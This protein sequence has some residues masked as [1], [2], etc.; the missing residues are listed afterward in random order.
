MNR[1]KSVSIIL[2]A[3]NET[4]SM[5]ETVRVIL[6]TC[7]INDICELFIVLCDRSTTECI[8]AATT[9]ENMAG[10]IPTTIYYQN[11]PF[12][13][14]AMRE[15]FSQVK[16]SHVIMMSTDLE[17]D[18]YL[19]SKMIES[20]KLNPDSITTASR[21]IKGGGFKGY[22]KLKLVSNYF[23]QKG[24]SFLFFTRNTD[25]TYGYRIFPTKLM[26]SI[27]WEEEK[28]PFFLETAL[29]PLRLGVKIIELPTKWEARTEGESQN[30][31]FENF[32]YIKTVLRVRFMKKRS[33]LM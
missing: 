4:Y 19:V 16:G 12:V 11:K 25:L 7:D 21:W 22:S 8:S 28:H 17:T 6:D 32:K 2:P 10:N 29:K 23:F 33:I 9:V 1:F 27:R 30:A 13:G 5:I 18:P 14:M 31:F 26:Q 20:A 24:L 15:A 3:I